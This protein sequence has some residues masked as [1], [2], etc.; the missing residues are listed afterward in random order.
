MSGLPKEGAAP[1]EFALFYASLGWSVI[2][3][4]APVP[5]GSGDFICSC[6]QRKNC[7]KP[8][9]HPRH[10]QNTLPHGLKS[11]TTV[12]DLVRRWWATWPDA[13]VG[14]QTGRESGIVV[15]DVDP[16]HGVHCGFRRIQTSN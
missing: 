10:D 2:P 15:L 1:V 14:I 4:H 11:A 9:K 7:P 16:R 13:N 12:S 5:D 3:L 6:H 8:G